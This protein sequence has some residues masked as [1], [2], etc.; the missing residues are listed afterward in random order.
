MSKWQELNARECGGG[1]CGLPAGFFRVRYFHG[2]EMRLADYVDEQRYHAGKMR[3]HNGRLHGAGIL[4]GLKVC[5]LGPGG[6]VVRVGK[7]AAIDACGREIIVGFDQCVDV[8]AWFRAQRFKYKDRDDNPCKPDKDRRVRICVAIRYAECSGAPEPA[9]TVHCDGESGG[10]GCGCGGACEAECTCDPCAPGADFG[11]V[12]EEFELRLMFHGEARACATEALFPTEEAISDALAMASGAVG[13][14]DALKAPVRAGCP[15]PEAGWLVLACFD[16]VLDDH[17]DQKIV[18]IEDIDY[19][20]AAPVLLSAAVIQYLLAQLFAEA[21]PAIG[22]PEVVDMTLRKLPRNRYQFALTLSAPIEAA[23]LDEDDSFN[24]R[25]LTAL[26][27]RAPD[28]NAVSATYRDGAGGEYR[29]DGPAIYVTV[30]NASGFLVEGGRYQLYAP[31]GGQPVVD[32]PLRQLRPRHLV[33]R[34][35]LGTDPG[36]GELVMRPIGA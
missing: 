2:K 20:C 14:L 28:N 9:P 1:S 4:C 29:V 7:G 32:A 26:G 23:S 34:F 30:D 25:A 12:T 24:L 18:A 22:G 33:Y 3:L 21:D 16:L 15:S 27:W 11:R 35:G 13:L 17:D 5:L 10:C 31:D 8:D 19:D 36:S 6:L